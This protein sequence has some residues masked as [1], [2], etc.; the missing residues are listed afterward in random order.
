M[1]CQVKLTKKLCNNIY[2]V[3]VPHAQEYLA[4]FDPPCT[5]ISRMLTIP[6][7][8]TYLTRLN[9]VSPFNS[10]KGHFVKNLFI[11]L[12]NDAQSFIYKLITND[13][14]TKQK[15]WIIVK[16]HFLFSNEPWLRA[17]ADA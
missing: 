11:P 3:H 16:L 8:W 4:K 1:I 2:I 10:F 5:T 13:I 14:P 15:S 9:P 6:I 7:P 12:R 17:C